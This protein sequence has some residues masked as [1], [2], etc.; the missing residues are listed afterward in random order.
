MASGRRK[1]Q[2]EVQSNARKVKQARDS[3]ERADRKTLKAF[4]DAMFKHGNEIKEGAKKARTSHRKDMQKITKWHNDKTREA[5]RIEDRKRKERIEALKN[6]DETK[7]LQ[8]LKSP[9]TSA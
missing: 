1:F 8:M 9:R 5:K 6:Q 7:Y 4:F 2:K 3:E